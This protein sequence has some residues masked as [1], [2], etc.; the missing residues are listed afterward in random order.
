MN[1]RRIKIPTHT[2]I[3]G[4]DYKWVFNII[5]W[6]FVIAIS[7]ATISSSVLEDVPILI[8]FLLLI[9]FIFLGIIFDMIGIAVAAASEVP[10]HSMASHG[11]K[12]AQRAIK[13]VRNAEKVSNFCNDVVGDISGILSGSIAGIIILKM[14]ANNQFI[15]S[16][17]MTG[18]VSAL[19]V[20]GKAIGKGFAITRSNQIVYYVSLLVSYLNFF[21]KKKDRK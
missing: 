17:L 10:F 5:I 12:G 9:A 4:T 21:K 1:K 15:W 2:N 19:T 14:A 6:T 7:L 3:K 8:A 13:I 16:V 18:V 20:S 11:V